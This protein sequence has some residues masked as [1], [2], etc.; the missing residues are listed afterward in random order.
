M[1]KTP[2]NDKI[3]VL[4]LERKEEKIGS[5]VIPGTTNAELSVGR[6]AAVSDK[7]KDIFNV[8]DNV[9]YPSRSGVGQIIDGK[10]YLWLRA[11]EIWGIESADKQ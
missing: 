10:A 11:D 1:N 3:I 7:L 4:P 8:D 5:V 9:I 6:V 2:V